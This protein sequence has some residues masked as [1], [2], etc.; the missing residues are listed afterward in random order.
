MTFGSGWV[1]RRRNETAAEATAKAT[2]TELEKQRG[3]MVNLAKESG[4]SAGRAE[5]ARELGRLEGRVQ[6]PSEL[7]SQR[8]KRNV[9]RGGGKTKCERVGSHEHHQV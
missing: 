4:L 9:A 2:T 3:E 6:S 8:S 5:M 1:Q 7:L